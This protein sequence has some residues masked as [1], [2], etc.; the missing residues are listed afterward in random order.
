MWLASSP[1][2]VSVT[3]APSGCAWINSWRTSTR[4]S[5]KCAGRYIRSPP[6][7]RGSV[8]HG[9]KRPR[10]Q[11]VDRPADVEALPQPAWTRRLRV[12]IEPSCLVPCPKRFDGIVGYRWRDRNVGQQPSVRGPE[13]QL[14]VGLS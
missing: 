8:Y 4:D 13:S 10:M 1:P 6:C 5:L 3:S 14:T 2:A 12:Q 9:P 7:R 11:D